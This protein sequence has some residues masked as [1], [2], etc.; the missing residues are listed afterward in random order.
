MSTRRSFIKSS[1]L[2]VAG[3]V[4][5]VNAACSNNSN[6]DQSVIATSSPSNLL[7]IG[8]GGDF[9]DVAGALN[10]I[11]DNSIDNPYLLRVLP[12]VY[13]LNWSPKSWTTIE[14]SGPLATIFVGSGWDSINIGESDVHLKDFGIRFTGS[15]EGHVAIHRSGA[16]SGVHLSG[17]HI[18]HSG[19]GAAIRNSGG[20]PKL[21]WWLRDLKIR[22]E[23]IGLDIGAVT[24]CDDIKIMLYG[25][26]SGH[27]HVGCRITGNSTRTYLNQC[28]IGTGYAYDY[29]DGF[30]TNEVS[31]DDD[32][33][34]LW[35]PAGYQDSHVE[36]HGMESF[37]RNEDTVSHSVNVNVL[38]IE[39]SWVRAYGCFGQAETPAD[40]SIGSSIY[41][42]GQGKIEQY[43]CR[44]SGITGRTFGSTTVGIQTFTFA[45]DGYMFDKFEGGLHRLNASDGPFMLRLRANPGE[46]HIFKKIDG[47]NQVTI[48]LNGATLDGNPANVVLMDAYEKLSIVWNGT[49][50]VRV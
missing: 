15:D 49:E 25:T 47:V 23:G 29:R 16:A 41:Q 3:S 19:H 8:P 32:V 17:I 30:I 2:P 34:G 18:E 6:Q 28:R 40:W 33:L 35:I 45:D 43:G 11:T 42:S 7:N 1:L 12:G 5:L 10:S 9:D 36:I 50:W 4:V 46:M 39:T 22:T 26:N 44:F 24:Y 31:G 20:D 37:C 21:T 48:D 38:R 13:S 27:S 14:G